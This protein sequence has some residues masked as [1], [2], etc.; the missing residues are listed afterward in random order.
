MSGEVPKRATT[1]HEAAFKRRMAAIAASAALLIM[2]LAPSSFLFASARANRNAADTLAAAIA[3]DVA[4][5]A[6]RDPHLWRYNLPKIVRATG[7]HDHEVAAIEV[8]DCDRVPLFTSQQ[9][10]F[11]RP[12]K[13]SAYAPVVTAHGVVAIVGV[14]PGTGQ[15]RAIA[16]RLG[17]IGAVAGLIA[18][19]ALYLVPTRVVRR[20]YR[21]LDAA[22]NELGAAQ[23]DLKQANAGL[24]EAVDGAVARVRELSSRAAYVQEQERS[25][26]AREL[27]DTLG[28]HLGAVR[29]ELDALERDEDVA[30]RVARLRRLTDAQ[31]E[32][33]RR[34]IRDLRPAELEERPFA[35]AIEALG[36]QVELRSGVTLS[37]GLQGFENLPSSSAA[38]LFRV[39]QEALTNAVRHGSPSEIGVRGR[40]EDGEVLLIIRDDG[41]GGAKVSPRHGLDFMGDRVAAL[42]GE[43]D[44][45]SADDGTTLTV[46]VPIAQA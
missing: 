21:E 38:A 42:G 15:A 23:Q 34:A 37:V 16:V 24:E 28:Q 10:G 3:A 9:L 19:L 13:T 14:A 7:A 33:L 4:A 31:L 17:S 39:V 22:A 46:R 25:R 27:H 12:P 41:V 26:I 20:Q 43:L 5:V 1:A 40:V 6:A 11:D 36:E 45:R 30:G 32:D 2:C 29:L 44:L 35:D 8:L 18:G